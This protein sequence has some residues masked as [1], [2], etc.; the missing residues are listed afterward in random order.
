MKKKPLLIL[1]FLILTLSTLA[2]QE[3]PSDFMKGADVSFLAE[4]ED[5]GGKFYEKGVYKDVLDLFKDHGFN[6]VRLKIWH[7]PR[8]NYDNLEK[9][10]RTAQRAKARGFRLLLNF[11]YSDGWADPQKQIK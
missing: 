2:A 3:K 5:M 9:V 11:H 1:A 4:I 10:L 6:Y 7:T 8:K